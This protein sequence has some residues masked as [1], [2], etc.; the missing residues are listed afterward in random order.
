MSDER[1]AA[2][3]GFLVPQHE[4]AL[5]RRQELLDKVREANRRSLTGPDCPAL[6]LYR[7]GMLKPFMRKLQVT[8]DDVERGDVVEVGEL[9]HR[10]RHV[11]D[12]EG[13]RRRL[14]FED[15]NAYVLEA[16]VLITV[17]RAF[18]AG[19]M[20]GESSGT[21]VLRRAGNTGLQEDFG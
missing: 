4:E 15:G 10:V 19:S 2:V 18:D 8:G 12:L 16:G 3:H 6:H 20:V 17:A 14:E 1:R 21:D 5:R 13:G 9:L 11:L 7:S